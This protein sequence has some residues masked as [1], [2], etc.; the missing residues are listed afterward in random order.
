MDY[1]IAEQA[2]QHALALLVELADATILAEPLTLDYREA[3]NVTLPLDVKR[4]NHVLGTDMTAAD[5]A[6]SF[7]RLQFETTNEGDR[8]MVK[9]PSRRPDISIEADLLE[10]VGRIYGY[11][12]LPSTLPKGEA[13]PGKLSY[14]QQK[15]TRN[16]SLTR[17]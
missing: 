12:K 10:E 17:R 14:S 9:V 4:V 13:T 5:V 16:A 6:T 8:F 1:F 7:S 11:D 3:F 15:N 2:R